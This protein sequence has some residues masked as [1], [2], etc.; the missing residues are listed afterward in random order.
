M[1]RFN[2]SITLLATVTVDAMDASAAASEALR[3]AEQCGP[4]DGFIE[5]WN[6]VQTPGAP[7]IVDFGNI[8]I[9]GLD[10]DDVR[11]V[12]VCRSDDCDGSIDNGEGYNGFCG[13]CADRLDNDDDL[14]DAAEGEECTACHRPSIDCSR[15]PCAAVIADRGED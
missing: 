5:G 3:F 14:E 12:A 4:Q 1:K 10:D 11:E 13:S 7:L 8:D 15:A 6:S 9:E 2:I